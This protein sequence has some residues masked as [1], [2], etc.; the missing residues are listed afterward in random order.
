MSMARSRWAIEP[1]PCQP[2]S[3][4][5]TPSPAASAHALPCGTPGH[6]SGTRRRHTPGS[7][8]SPR[9]SSRLRRAVAMRPLGCQTADSKEGPDMATTEQASSAAEVARSYFG[10]LAR[11][12][13]GAQ[14]EWYG[15]DMGGQIF[16]VIGPAGREEMI[17]YFDAL[18][19][20]LP[21]FRLEILDIVA[22]GDKAAVRWRATGTFA[23]PAH[24]Q[25]LEPNG[26]R[27]DV[28][29]CDVVRVA[30]GKV[31]WIDAYTDNATI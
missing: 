30:D 28:E 18:Y 5:T 15:P 6:G 12:D 20:A 17:A 8:R 9:P 16:G 26:A 1:G 11:A 24:F 21:D 31:A 7:T 27:I 19:A 10:A 4:S 29:G 3:T 13:R 23:G 14:R 2:V 25:G 22:E